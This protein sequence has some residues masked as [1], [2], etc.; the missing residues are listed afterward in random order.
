[1]KSKRESAV[2]GFG[3]AR[4]CVY[5]CAQE[6][7]SREKAQSAQKKS[8][9]TLAIRF[10]GSPASVFLRLFRLFAAIPLVSLTVQWLELHSQLLWR[11]YPGDY[12]P[13][14]IAS[15]HAKPG[16]QKDE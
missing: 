9:R 10:G 14:L 4:L 12:H 16:A 6:G 3:V 8:R 1:M 2:S 11:I 7:V 5:L 13:T 15:P